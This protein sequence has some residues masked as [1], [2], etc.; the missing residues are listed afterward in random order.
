MLKSDNDVVKYDIPH[1]KNS[2]MLANVI[3]SETCR[4][5]VAAAETMGFTPDDAIGGSATTLTSVLAH[6]FYWMSDETFC[7]ALFD[8]IKDFLPQEIN[9]YQIRSINR[10]FRTYRYVPGALYRVNF[11]YLD[12]RYMADHGIASH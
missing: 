12:P 6:N 8:R 9:G 1:L 4:E 7:T 5:V 11:V 2:F 10:R 3:G